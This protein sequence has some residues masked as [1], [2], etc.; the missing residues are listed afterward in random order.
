MVNGAWTRHLATDGGQ[1]LSWVGKLGLMFG[2]TEAYD[3]HYCVIGSLGDRLLLCCP[4]SSHD[5]HLR[6]RALHQRNARAAPLKDN[7]EDVAR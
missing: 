2:A 7:D 5:G 1:T 4:V 3:D 6:R